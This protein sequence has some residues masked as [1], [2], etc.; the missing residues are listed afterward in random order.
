MDR[1][2]LSLMRSSSLDW[3]QTNTQFKTV[4]GKWT[5]PCLNEV[6]M[7]HR[8]YRSNFSS[9]E[10]SHAGAVLGVTSKLHP[11]FITA[12]GSA[13]GSLSSDHIHW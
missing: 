9:A 5:R 7:F 1:H 3:V 6:I 4:T 11:S 13:A 2:Q 8:F 10:W 12:G